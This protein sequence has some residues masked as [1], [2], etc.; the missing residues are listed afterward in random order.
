[1]QQDWRMT[2]YDLDLDSRMVE[3]PGDVHR[4]LYLRDGR[5]SVETRGAEVDLQPDEGRF[6]R[7]GARIRGEG[8]VWVFEVGPGGRDFI[9]DPAVSIVLSRRFGLDPA[10]SRLL[11]ADRIESMSG[12]AT[13]RH[14]HRGPGMRRLIM[15]RLLAEIGDDFER[16]DAGH[17]WF[18]TGQ[19]P[20]IG[21]NIHTGNSA[22]VR[23]MLLPVELEG[24]K[25]SFMP[26][27]AE[28]AAKPRA[29]VNRLF[30][31]IVIVGVPC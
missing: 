9:S 17:A 8:E 24:G 25:S 23:V 27:T 16:I 5:A 21:T 12:S 30:G 13:P 6:S 29:V 28:D 10:P 3:L 26:T 20:V 11:R 14:G 18:E 31:E 22:F 2:V 19:D 15:G 7:S 4:F 1:M